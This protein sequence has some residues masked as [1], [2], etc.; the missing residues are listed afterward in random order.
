MRSFSAVNALP[1]RCTVDDLKA[2]QPFRPAALLQLLL[3][4]LAGLLVGTHLLLSQR[5]RWKV[6]HRFNL[7]SN[8][9]SGSRN[10]HSKT[11]EQ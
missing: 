4:P 3:H 5:F 1:V 9:E 10:K 2:F 7:D 11:W 8:A 6:R